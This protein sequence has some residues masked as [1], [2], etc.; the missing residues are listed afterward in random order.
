MVAKITVD[1]R[2]ARQLNKCDEC[3]P[4]YLYAW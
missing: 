2:M 3:S 1:T 4:W